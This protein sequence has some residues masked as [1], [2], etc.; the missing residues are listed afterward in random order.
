MGFF[1]GRVLKV[2]KREAGQIMWKYAYVCHGPT[3]K[4]SPNLQPVDLLTFPSTVV[5]YPEITQ[6]DHQDALLM[7]RSLE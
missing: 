2:F 5:N 4:L 1:Q 6:Q 7:K 3:G